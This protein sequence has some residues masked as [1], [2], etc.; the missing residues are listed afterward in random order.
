M[1]IVGPYKRAGARGEGAQRSVTELFPDTPHMPGI[2]AILPADR[3]LHGNF[4]G[5]LLAVHY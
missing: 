5:T 1:G 2:G 4:A 3:G